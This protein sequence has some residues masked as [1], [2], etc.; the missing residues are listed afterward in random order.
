MKNRDLKPE[1]ILISKNKIVKLADFSMSKDMKFQ[2]NYKTNVY[3]LIFSQKLKRK[4]IGA[5]NLRLESQRSN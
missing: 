5:W 1:N 3:F 2:Q 4:N